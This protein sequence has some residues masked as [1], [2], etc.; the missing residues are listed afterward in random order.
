M[1]QRVALT[2]AEKRYIL[3]RK[4]S[5]AS[6]GQIAQELTCSFQ[7]VRK[8]WRYQRDGRQPRR[9]GRPAQGVLST[10]P[11]VVRAKAVELKQA[12]PHWGPASV[13]LG[14]NEKALPGE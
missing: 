2:E 9:R 3:Q 8:W 6:L 11:E 12:H 10:Y 1:A 4:E 5:G 7:T 13:K 14:S